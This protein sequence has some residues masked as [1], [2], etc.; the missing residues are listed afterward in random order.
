MAQIHPLFSSFS[1]L[2]PFPHY[3][4]H[5]GLC[6]FTEQAQLGPASGPVHGLCPLLRNSSTQLLVRLAPSSIMTPIEIPTPQSGLP[7]PHDLNRSFST[8]QLSS[9][10]TPQ[11]LIFARHMVNSEKCAEISSGFSSKEGCHVPEQEGLMGDIFLRIGREEWFVLWGS[12][13]RM[14][15]CLSVE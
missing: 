8:T 2:S 12:S 3:S 4:G 13:R 9:T 11:S 10:S 15:S 7:C 1:S 6:H 5:I 14:T